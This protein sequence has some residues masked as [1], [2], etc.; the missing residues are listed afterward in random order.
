MSEHQRP[1]AAAVV[2]HG[3]RVLMV[4]RAVPEGEL[5]WQFPAGK[6]EPGETPAD[7][8]V[9]ETVEE[10]GVV[11]RLA[12]VIGERVH[13]A[14]GRH[15][16]YLACSVERGDARIPSGDE[17]AEV[18]WVTLTELTDLVPHG[19]FEPVQ[20]HVDAELDQQAGLISGA[21]R[22]TSRKPRP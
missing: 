16:T 11:T 3:G 1:V 14:T 18:R 2:V 9:R 7:A 13:P 17:V 19:L 8:A 15:I 22:D 5:V 4:R 10:T 6:I 12:R 21:S 20:R